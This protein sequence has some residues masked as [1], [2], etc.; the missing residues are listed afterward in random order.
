MQV[1]RQHR[2][3]LLRHCIK[4][5]NVVLPCIW[6]WSVQYHHLKHTHYVHVGNIQILFCN[7][8][9]SKIIPD[10]RWLRIARIWMMICNNIHNSISRLWFRSSFLW[11][12]K[13]ASA[14]ERQ[15]CCA[16]KIK[17]G[18]W[19][20]RAGRARRRNASQLL[21]QYTRSKR[22]CSSNNFLFIEPRTSPCSSR[23]S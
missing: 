4:T 13:D 16:K 22:S 17:N 21:S 18:Q 23:C 19:D 1:L 10:V 8:F 14:I 6:P 9:V 15:A 20:V 11:L 2:R 7:K 3:L 12:P 5:S